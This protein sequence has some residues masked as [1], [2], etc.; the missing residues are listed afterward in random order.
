MYCAFTI[1]VLV[2]LFPGEMEY[3]KIGI[4][5]QQ[6]LFDCF[7]VLGTILVGGGHSDELNSHYC[8]Q[9][10][11]SLVGGRFP[12]KIWTLTSG[13]SRKTEVWAGFSSRQLPLGSG[14]PLPP[15]SHRCGLSSVVCHTPHCSLLSHL[16]LRRSLYNGYI[17]TIIATFR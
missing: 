2:V 7:Y 15:F 8:P 10:A 1:Q 5:I 13:S 3:L 14:G 11:D 4:I 6:I 16:I 12:V 17:I 9:G